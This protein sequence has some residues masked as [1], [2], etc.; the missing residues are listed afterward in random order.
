M[1]HTTSTSKTTVG[2]R[3]I[4]WLTDLHLDRTPEDPL[5]RFLR[6]LADTEC[7]AFL[8]TGDIS[9]A[10]LIARHLRLIAAAC[11]PRMVYFTLGNHDFHSG[12]FAGVDGQI[13]A[14]CQEIRNLHHLHGGHAVAVGPNTGLIGHRG[15]PDAQAG[16]GARTVIKDRDH[17]AIADFHGKSESSVFARMNRLGTESAAAIRAVLPAALARHP[18]VVIATHV[19]PFPD[20]A[21]YSR[22]RCGPTHQPHF[23][24]LSVGN[25]IYEIAKHHERNRITVLCGHTHCATNRKIRHNIDVKV[26]GAKPGTPGIAGILD[27]A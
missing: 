13:A 16:W 5:D 11:A 4:A 23:V 6:N 9:R 27:V 18:N 26:G 1:K 17:H 12:S 8:I 10:P 24:N 2:K 7:H 19:P 3:K 25:M 15:W 14:L 22:G 20:A 21:C